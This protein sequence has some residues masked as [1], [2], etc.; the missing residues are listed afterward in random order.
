[1][2]GGISINGTI[3]LTSPIIS[4]SSPAAYLSFQ[5][6]YALSGLIVE[7]STSPP[8]TD[9]AFVEI[10]VNGGAWQ[11]LLGP[12]GAALRWNGTHLDWSKVYAN[13]TANGAGAGTMRLRWGATGQAQAREGGWW[14]DDLFVV[15][16]N[17]T[18]GM[19]VRAARTYEFIEPGGQTTYR[20]KVINVGDFPDTYAFRSDLPP[21]WDAW[22]RLNVTDI[23]NVT[24]FRLTLDTDHE[25]AV[26]LVV[27]APLNIIRG[28]IASLAVEAVSAGDARQTNNLRLTAEVYDP[29]GIG[30]FLR[31]LPLFFLLLIVLAAIVAVIRKIKSPH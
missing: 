11:P 7:N 1:Y 12:T 5:H 22:I 27:Q 6:K 28:T 10:Q 21:R 15:A 14:L 17:L 23:T 2:G 19:A 16:Q 29:V 30:K 25:T 18:Y 26:L 8:E 31:Y 24:A 3:Y 4:L 20:L 13:L 9:E